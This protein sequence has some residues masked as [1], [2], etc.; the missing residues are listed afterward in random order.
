M[1]DPFHVTILER[2]LAGLKE[3]TYNSGGALDSGPSDWKRDAD[4]RGTTS[5]LRQTNG[6]RARIR[7]Y[8]GIVTSLETITDIV[9]GFDPLDGSLANPG[10][11]I[12]ALIGRSADRIGQARF[13]LTRVLYQLDKNE[14]EKTLDGG[15]RGSDKRFW[16][17]R[18]P[19]SVDV[20]GDRLRLNADHF[21]PVDANLIPTGELCPVAGTSCDFHKPVASGARI[22]QN[23]EQLKLGCGFDHNRA[24]N[25]NGEGRS[26]AA[27]VEESDSGRVLE[28]LTGEPGIR[29]YSGIFRD[30]SIRRKGGRMEG[31]P[32][33]LCLETG[34]FPDSPNQP[35]SAS[36][37]RKP[38]QTF[39]STTVFRFLTA[40]PAPE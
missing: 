36:T 39:R 31:R 35:A 34:H 37:E 20:L 19:G 40:A 25:R 10:P 38:P 15:P 18:A 11:S 17:R 12:G 5:E 23:D 28:V 30:G 9:R 14:G 1:S 7:I 4:E 27:R 24:L 29:F 32:R 13:A 2:R 8:G 33:G 3:S 16:T 22:D 21:N 26:L 6:L